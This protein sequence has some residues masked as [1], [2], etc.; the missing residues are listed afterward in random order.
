MNTKPETY[1]MTDKSVVSFDNI[2][3]A[4]A[5]KSNS[6]LRADYWLFKMIGQRWLVNMAPPLTDLALKLHLP[7]K[8]IIRATI[9][10]HFCG[11]EDINDC[12]NTIANLHRFN[13]GSILDYSVEGEEKEENFDKTRDEIIATVKRAQGDPSIPFCVFKITG[14]ARFGLLERAS[15]TTN[16]TSGEFEEYKRVYT[17]VKNICKAAAEANV[18]IFI[19]AEESWIQPAI[20]DFA[21]QM[22][23]HYNREK[24]IVYNTIQ[25]YRTDRFAFLEKSLAHAKENNYLLGLKLVRGAY[26][27]KERARAEKM[28]YPSPI[29]PDKK[30]ADVDFDKA[31]HVCVNNLDRIAFCAGTHN[32]ESSLLLVKLMQ[33]KNIAINHPSVY[34]SQLL[35]MSDH[36]SYNLASAGYNVA[37]YVPYGPVKSVLPYLIRRAHENTSIAGQMGRELA[38]I[39]AERKRRNS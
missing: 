16:L 4:F 23:V 26:M 7:I 21:E 15:V 29:Q 3:R 9:F 37:K 6:E 14:I 12:N 24:T 27:E 19:D 38:L 36:I 33:E 20:D 35:G 1:F 11:G 22:M 34:F 10:K 2:E 32:E 8:G 25:F 39:V 17:R 5:A 28:D 31:L 30:S 13:I 18:R